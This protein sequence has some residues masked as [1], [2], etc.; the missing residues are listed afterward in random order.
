MVWCGV[1]QIIIH[2]SETFILPR[3][4]SSTYHFLQI[5]LVLNLKC[6]MELN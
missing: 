3:F 6:G 2:F 4:R 1:N 5:I